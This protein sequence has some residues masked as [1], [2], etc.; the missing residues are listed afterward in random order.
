LAINKNLKEGFLTIYST[1]EKTIKRFK[2]EKS[3][4]LGS[5]GKERRYG[6]HGFKDGDNKDARG[7]RGGRSGRGGRGGRGDRGGRGAI[8]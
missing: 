2:I 7:G 1:D 3:L 8:N 6:N 5:R 4:L